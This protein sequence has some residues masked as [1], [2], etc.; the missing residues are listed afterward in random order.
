MKCAT[1]A[2]AKSSMW[3]HWYTVKKGW[4]VFSKD[5]TEKTVLAKSICVD[6][7]QGNSSFAAGKGAHQLSHMK[8]PERLRSPRV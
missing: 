2:T 4:I 1:A 8:K 3:H 7:H 5:I 6:E